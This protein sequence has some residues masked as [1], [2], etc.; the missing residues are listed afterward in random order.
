[1]KYFAVFCKKELLEGLRTHRLLI[2]A[3]V[4]LVFGML[5]PLTAKFTPDMLGALM[6][7]G[8]NVQISEP[9]TAD[10]WMQFY[11]NVS[12]VGIIVLVVVFGGAVSTEVRRGTLIPLL[13][14]GL[15]RSAVVLAKFAVTS[16]V[17]TVCYW[18]S[19][20]ACLGYTA[21]MFPGGDVQNAL[22]SAAC[23]WLFGIF[24]LAVLMLASSLGRGTGGSLLITGGVWLLLMLISII[25]AAERFNPLTLATGNMALISGQMSAAHVAPAMVVACVGAGAAIACACAV[26]SRKRL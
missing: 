20:L 24:L 8:L 25:P 22:F 1:M 17:W 23:L 2:I 21:Y 5:S 11:K 15:P 3:I 26:F 10:S 7:E 19:Y 9:T 13:T 14:K 12:Q 16:L 6:P 18:L 4:L